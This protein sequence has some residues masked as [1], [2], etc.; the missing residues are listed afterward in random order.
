MAWVSDG[1]K[2]ATPAPRHVKNY[3]QYEHSGRKG[4]SSCAAIARHRHRGR[5]LALTPIE[6]TRRSGS[7]PRRRR[8]AGAWA[9]SRRIF[10]LLADSFRLLSSF[11]TGYLFQPHYEIMASSFPPENPSSGACAWAF[12]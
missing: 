4:A 10:R 9:R 8:I 5:R 2:S 7:P 3:R 1:E 12:V 6:P 11:V